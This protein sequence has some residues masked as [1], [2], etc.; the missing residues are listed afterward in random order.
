MTELVTVQKWLQA[1]IVDPGS[2]EEALLAAEQAAGLGPNSAEN[3]ILPSPTLEPAERLQ[4]YRNMYLLRMEEALEMDFPVVQQFVGERAFFRLV[5]E[6]VEVFPSRSWTLD[7][8]GL[9]FSKFLGEHKTLEHSGFLRDMARVEWALCDAFN[10]RNSNSIQ[11]TDLANVDPSDFESLI[12]KP[13]PAL[14]VLTVDHNVNAYYK[15]WVLDE[16]TPEPVEEP[17]WLLIW[18]DSIDFKRWRLSVSEAGHH[19]LQLLLAQK[20]LGESLEDTIERYEIPEA[21]LFEWFS[22]WVSEGLFATY[23]F[24]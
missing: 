10:S 18:R 15:K 5:G 2:D 24:G 14:Q 17:D 8:L 20:T 3:M 1:F 22:G 6:Y 19:F 16:P 11:M 12:L 7:H 9:H 23:T 4:I 21:E 13:I